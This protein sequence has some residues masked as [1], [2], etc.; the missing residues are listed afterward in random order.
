MNEPFLSVE[1]VDQVIAELRIPDPGQATIREIVA[2][3]NGVEARS[4][5]KYVRMEM[6]V[7]GLKPAQVGIDAEVEALRRGVAS[8]YPMV[9]GVP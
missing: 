2:L 1:T 7:P 8:I 5:V 4:G 6:G 9:D 3:V